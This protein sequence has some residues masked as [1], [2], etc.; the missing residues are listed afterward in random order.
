MPATTSVRGVAHPHA[1]GADRRSH[2]LNT[3]RAF[4][5]ACGRSLYDIQS[6][7]QAR[8]MG[9]AGLR[10]PYFV[11]DAKIG[12]WKDDI[13]DNAIYSLVDVD[14][15]LEME[16]YLNGS[17]LPIRPWLI[18]T[19]I[20]AH[21]GGKLGDATY[22][23][24]ADQTITMRSGGSSAYTHPLWDWSQDTISA[25]DGECV[26]VY[27]V[28]VIDLGDSRAIV[29]LEPHSRIELP[30]F[31]I[32]L[33]FS[34]T[35]ALL[36]LYGRVVGLEFHPVFTSAYAALFAYAGD[37]L[38]TA[39]SHAFLQH[40]LRPEAVPI[41]RLT[42]VKGGFAILTLHADGDVHYSISE[43]GRYASANVPARVVS[44]VHA[45]MSLV[46]ATTYV[47]SVEAVLRNNAV[48]EPSFAAPLL[49]AALKAGALDGPHT[50]I[51]APMLPCP[52]RTFFTKDPKHTDSFEEYGTALMAPLSSGAYF[53][54]ENRSNDLACVKGRVDNV[55]STT[56]VSKNTL[57][58]LE[59]FV[60]FLIP[61]PFLGV[62]ASP[63]Q[64]T[65]DWNRPSQ[66]AE[67]NKSIAFP[68][69]D[70][71]ITAFQKREG[72]VKLTDARNISGVKGDSKINEACIVV[73]ISALV[74]IRPFYAFSK[75]PARTE[76]SVASI[77]TGSRAI[78][79]SDYSRFD[80][81]QGPVAPALSQAVALRYYAPK[82][83]NQVLAALAPFTGAKGRT[84][85]GVKIDYGT[86]M[87]SGRPGTSLWNTLLNAF[88]VYMA[89][90]HHKED[91]HFY[92][93]QQAWNFLCEDVLVG[94]D[95]GIVSLRHI[96]AEDL[97]W[98]A[99]HVGLVLECD[100]KKNGQPFGFLGRVYGPS[101]WFNAPQ[102]TCNIARVLPK[103]HVTCTPLNG[104]DPKLILLMKATSYMVD[105][106]RSP[107]IGPIVSKL[108]SVLR[109]LF[110]EVSTDDYEVFRYHQT[111]GGGYTNDDVE[112]AH[113][114]FGLDLASPGID[115]WLQERPS[116]SEVESWLQR[117]PTLYKPRPL[118]IGK[119]LV[120]DVIFDSAN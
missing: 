46:K 6:S 117:F 34:F 95:D 90:R 85:H 108:V 80:G 61:E 1:L 74:K 57:S 76:Q 83:H 11:K 56:L 116:A 84:R 72:Y 23:W 86:G 29:V 4:A 8:K 32:E 49:A 82:Y 106:A 110:P 47:S 43:V 21:A 111:D 17:Y 109:P 94:G 30:R 99:A 67:S 55:R 69:P 27:D 54:H 101:T 5:L 92:S 10:T 104:R 14:Y 24:N 119:W 3:M 52:P 107:L 2:A 120:D 103:F 40:C 118:K 77:A 113:A 51:T 97:E 53:P 71:L 48:P 78:A 88:V 36:S 45:R 15:Y 13:P 79:E 39:L 91:G 62:P 41:R 38:Q 63:E 93:P 18:Y 87:L 16:E 25:T 89:F 60:S 64:V 114:H 35:F 20:P 33:R 115:D 37:K 98:A 44:E 42:P 59:E 19:I 50:E 102:S 66:V 28:D 26:V 65:S 112:W 68:Y 12:V 100:V 75:E 73:P 81:S 9:I 105:D 96:D 7:N 58:C 31:G 22:K 70:H